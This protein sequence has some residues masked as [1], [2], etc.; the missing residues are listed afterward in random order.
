MITD[1][2]LFG[3]YMSA[4]ILVNIVKFSDCLDTTNVAFTFFNS[5]LTMCDVY[6]RMMNNTQ[7]SQNIVFLLSTT[8]CPTV[9]LSVP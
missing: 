1:K 4:T 2:C 9:H 8:N 7:E 6:R 5:I 3:G